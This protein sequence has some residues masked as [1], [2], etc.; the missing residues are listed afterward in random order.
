MIVIVTKGASWIAELLKISNSLQ[1][2]NMRSNDIGDDGMSLVADALQYNRTLT[3]LN[4]R[5]CGLS[6]KGT[7]VYNTTSKIFQ[8]LQFSCS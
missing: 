8:S 5:E 7:V 2:L 1:E 6:V 4:I 3:K